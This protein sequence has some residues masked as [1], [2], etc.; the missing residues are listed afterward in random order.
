M[1]VTELGASRRSSF[2]AAPAEQQRINSIRLYSFTGLGSNSL[3][4]KNPFLLP[5]AGEAE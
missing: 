5:E 3:Q 2:D 4:E 1:D